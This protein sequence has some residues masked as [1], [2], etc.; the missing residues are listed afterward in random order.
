M[1]F[2][3]TAVS[4]YLLAA[5]AIRAEAAVAYILAYAFSMVFLSPDLDLARSRASKRWGIAR[6]L[7]IPYALVFRHRGC[8]HHAI[9]GAFTRVAYL[10]AVVGLLFVAIIALTGARI[11]VHLPPADVLLGVAAGLYVPNL[12]H[13]LSDRV[14][15]AWRGKRARKR[16]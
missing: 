11:A 6:V 5:G 10:A 15:S 4:G 14:V 1:L 13:I 7:W 16:L 3:W 9:L 2:V 8:S 12:T